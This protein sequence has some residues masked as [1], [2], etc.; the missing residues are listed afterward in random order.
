MAE[1]YK[2]ST[3]DVPNFGTK[4]II[5]LYLLSKFTSDR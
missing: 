4:T 5:I 1:D 2:L 3:T